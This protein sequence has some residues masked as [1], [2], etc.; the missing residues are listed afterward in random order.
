IALA[1]G[2]CPLRPG[3]PYKGPGHG[4]PP[5]P[6]VAVIIGALGT[7]N[8]PCKWSDRGWPTL[9]APTQGLQVATPLLITFAINHSKNA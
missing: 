5:L 6:H 4:R 8:H 3:L 2:N 7:A 1:T 9:Q